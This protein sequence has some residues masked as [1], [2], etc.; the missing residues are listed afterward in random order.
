MSNI[1]N[2]ENKNIEVTAEIGC[3]HQGDVETALKM[4]EE[5]ARAG[6]NNVK[7]QKRDNKTL[8]G[9]CIYNQIY[10]NP[11]SYGETYGDHRERLEL[12]A[13]DFERIKKCTTE[14]QIGLQV[15][16]FD[17]QSLEF[18]KKIGFDSYKIASAD[19]H[20]H[21]LIKKVCEV[22]KDVYLS[23]GGSSED[24]ISDSI[25]VVKDY[26]V[27]LTLYH[28][29]AAY[30]AAV[31]EMNLAYITKMNHLFGTSCTIG[32][33]DHENGIDAATVAYMLGARAFEKHFTLDRSLKGT[34]QSFSLEPV[35][36]KK[37]IR[38][39]KRIDEMLGSGEKQIFKSEERPL[40]K[41]V[42]SLIYSRDLVA[43]KKLDSEC[44][45]YRVT[46]KK[47]MRPSDEDKCLGKILQ[48]DVQAGSLVSAE[49]FK[50]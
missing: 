18:C 30:P 6:A 41:M 31:D 48:N 1:C 13:D 19:L 11:N 25:K 5:A 12:T 33:S 44:F 22:G 40:S 47:E 4:V 3:N 46:L 10:D 20:F 17:F 29:T 32:L 23:T 35:G 26:D 24:E 15:T 14:L 7:F 37:M 36:L 9:E 50:S 28:C 27:K 21:Q 45:D 38:N 49:D 16:P 2:A 34:D 39:L 42:K 43:G 8:F